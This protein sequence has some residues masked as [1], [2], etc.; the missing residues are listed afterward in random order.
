M[1]N[2]NDVV[3]PRII[4]K[5]KGNTPDPFLVTQ[6]LKEIAS[7]YNVAWDADTSVATVSFSTRLCSLMMSVILL[8]GISSD[9]KWQIRNV[10]NINGPIQQ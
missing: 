7:A 9:W 1:E 10:F 5:L 8:D 3:N 4:Q 2:K 6:Y